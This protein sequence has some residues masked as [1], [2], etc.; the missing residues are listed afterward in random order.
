[1][2]RRIPQTARLLTL[3]L[4]AA[5][6]AACRATP[7]VSLDLGFERLRVGDSTRVGA[8]YGHRHA[9]LFNDDVHATSR[10]DPATFTWT[11]SDS[12]VAT[13]DARGVVVA[14]RPGTTRVSARYGGVASSNEATIEVV[15]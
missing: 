4:C 14:R 2:T 12:A 11:L 7:V 10:D 13:I 5:A 1:M 6:G 3:A 8:V 9:G 15:P